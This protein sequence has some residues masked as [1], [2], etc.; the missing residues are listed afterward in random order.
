MTKTRKLTEIAVCAALATVCGFIKVWEMPQGGSIAFTMIPILV[1][2]FR[3]GAGTGILTG[4]IYGLIS[5][6][7][8]GVIY[9]PASI[10]LDYIVAFGAVGIAGFFKKNTFG[11]L[12]GSCV[13]VGARFVSSLIS[14]AMLFAEYAP[15]GQNP[16]IYSLGYQASYMVPELVICVAVLLLLHARARRIFEV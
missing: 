5:M 11:I 14:G 8:A 15:E 6:A 1:I 13:G 2:S 3:R 7:F 4:A 9:H 12:L 16:W 10:F